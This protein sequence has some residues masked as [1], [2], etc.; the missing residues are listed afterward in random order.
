MDEKESS[1]NEEQ[2]FDVNEI[3][4]RAR[5]IGRNLLNMKPKPLAS[6]KGKS[7]KDPIV[8]LRYPVK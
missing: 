8:N 2:E 6:Y 1:E 5:M 7:L 4:E 3:E